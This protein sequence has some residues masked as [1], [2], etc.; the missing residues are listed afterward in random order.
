MKTSILATLA[1]MLSELP[2]IGP[3]QARR[4]AEAMIR[5]DRAWVEELTRRIVEAKKTVRKC[6]ACMRT[7]F[8]GIGSC[9]I[10]ADSTRDPSTLLLVEKD[11]D[12]EAIERSGAYRG[13]Y[14]VLGSL[15]TPLDAEPERKARL[16]ELVVRVHS[17]HQAK[18][19]DPSPLELIFALPAN[20]DG[21]D[22]A[23]LVREYLTRHANTALVRTSELGRGLSTG[24]ELEYAD[25]K[26]IKYALGR[27][28]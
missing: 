12:L 20:E 11:V 19:T 1:D 18:A 14:F 4:I 13:N 6:P 5:K 24:S 10:C 21:D 25:A 16:R 28:V 15:V 3:R 7:V 17:L 22:T 9:T 23:L 2:G 26:T 8:G 27:R